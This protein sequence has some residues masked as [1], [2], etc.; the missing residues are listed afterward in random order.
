[1]AG[2]RKEVVKVQVEEGNVVQIS[3][4]RSK[5]EYDHSDTWHRIERRRGSFV[6]WFRLPENAELGGIRCR[7]ENG[8]LTLLIPKKGGAE[9]VAPRALRYIDVA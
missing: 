3:G 2:V 5:E 7:L 4:E 1:M 9:Q 8:V 6:R